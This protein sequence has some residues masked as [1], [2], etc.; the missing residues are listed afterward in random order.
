MRLI[1]WLMIMLV[2]S[3]VVTSCGQPGAAPP[4][5]PPAETATTAAVLPT[6]TATIAASPSPAATAER[7]TATDTAATSAASAT[8]GA[9]AT[10]ETQTITATDEVSAT[11]SYQPPEWARGAVIYQVFVRTFTP[12]GTLAA[13]TE[14]L[15]EIRDLGVDI[16]YLLPIH[17][18]GA[19]K[20]KGSL[21]SPYSVRDYRAIDPALG[22]ADDFRR[23]VDTAHQL[24]L[25]VMMDLVANH[26]AWDNP[27]VTEHPRWYSRNAAGQIIPPN[28]DWS[29]VADF[30][31]TNDELQQYMIDTSLYWVNEFGID[32]YRSDAADQVPIL[33]WRSWRA[34][35]KAARPDLLL[36]SESGGVVMYSAGFEVTYD[37]TTQGQFTQALLT[38]RLAQRALSQV[39][40]EQRRYNNQR[41]RMRY[42]ENHDQERIASVARTPEQ[43][44]LAA[45]FLLTI[46]GLSLIY[47]GQEVGATERPSLFEPHTVDFAGGDQA[48]RKVYADLIG[49]RKT[50][51]ALRLG[52]LTTMSTRQQPFLLYE[53]STDDQRVLVAIN[54]QAESVQI[55]LEDV[56]EGRDLRSGATVDL[57]KGLSLDGYG[58]RLIE[59]P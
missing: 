58:Y 18:I 53:R 17:P 15:P 50:N 39:A 22:T 19:E 11:D 49:L 23:F 41:W 3:V 10:A 54:M 30:N 32:G 57:T 45:A 56:T 14:R 43:R 59:L 16:V 46:P 29:D 2:L 5:A 7:A 12:E 37:W 47:A 48:L 20:R 24:G 55:P 21:G 1:R 26:S 44:A 31:Y 52:T 51:P 6:S 38:P 13:A 25:R 35:L 36:L 9:A 42:L 4:A 28:P 34:A 27:L 33:F 8:T 40:A